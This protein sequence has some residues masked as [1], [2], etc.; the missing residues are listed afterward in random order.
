MNAIDLAGR[1]AV[2]TGGAQGIG[3]AIAE[4]LLASGARVSLWDRD[5]ALLESAAGALANGDRVSM[6]TVELTD[7][8][9]VAK[10]A[11]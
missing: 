7:H 2:V 3:Y 10:A 11:D 5:A 8:A 6:E 9:A 4:R 1:G